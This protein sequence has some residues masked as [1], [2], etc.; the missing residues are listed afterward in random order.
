MVFRDKW[1]RW[2]WWCIYIA[3]FSILVNGLPA[4]FFPSSRGL[5]QG[6]PLSP[7]LFVMGMEVLS[8]LVRRATNGGYISGCVIKGR[9]E[10][11]LNISHLLFVDDTIVFCEAL[12]D[13]ILFL[14]WVFLWFEAAFEL[15]INW[16]RSELTSV[17]MVSNMDELAAEL[18]FRV[19]SLPTAYLGL[20]LRGCS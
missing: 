14:S 18:R 15:S 8:I 9:G 13:Q 1:V 6:D 4:G 11:D 5:R 2:I 19:G 10:V 12:K 20:H 7:Y 3:N 16:D 17:G